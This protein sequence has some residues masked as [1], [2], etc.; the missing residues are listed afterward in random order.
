MALSTRLAVILRKSRAGRM[1]GLNK[2]L[3]KLQGSRP[4][5]GLEDR[6]R[7]LD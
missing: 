3:K 2:R 1:K 5:V 4:G 7:V 6:R